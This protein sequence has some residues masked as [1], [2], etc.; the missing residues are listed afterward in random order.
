MTAW[1]KRM[2]TRG[3]LAA[4]ALALAAC[5]TMPHGGLTRAQTAMLRANGFSQTAQGWE[6][7][8]ADRLLFAVDSAEINGEMPATI[9]RIASNLQSVGIRRARVYGFTDASGST[10]YNA[11]LSQT[12]AGA[13]AAVMAASGFAPADL[14]VQGMGE[15]HPVADNATA[16]GRQQNRRVVIL[17]TAQ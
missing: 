10:E 3:A 14:D 17:I 11:Q 7:S 6:L 15:A 9:G 1:V 5:Q 8:F 12:R 2:A 13:V 4:I 16:E